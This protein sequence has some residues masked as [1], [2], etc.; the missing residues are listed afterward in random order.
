[1]QSRGSRVLWRGSALALAC[2]W[3]LAG[4]ATAADDGKPVATIEFKET[5]VGIGVGYS[6]GE[7]FLVYE[8]KRHPF[9]ITGLSAGE[10]GGKTVSARGEVYHLKKLADF[11]GTYTSAGAGATAAGGFDV[12]AMR[13]SN[14]V[15]IKVISTTQ[16]ADLK[17]AISGIKIT[18]E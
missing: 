3:V 7:G 14:G 5:S 18:L 2:V 6:W 12:E 4:S 8:G 9:K 16:G 10:L 15:E 13:N 17:A 11:S 1:M